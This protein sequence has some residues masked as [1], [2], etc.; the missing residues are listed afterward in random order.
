MTAGSPR[1]TSSGRVRNGKAR[2][3]AEIETD[4]DFAGVFDDT[5]RLAGVAYHE[6]APQ[7]RVGVQASHLRFI[8]LHYVY[9][10]TRGQD[11]QR[12]SDPAPV[13]VS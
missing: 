7:Q 12:F 8:A 1:L 13:A 6:P 2:R 3:R 4:H 11:G 5:S 10:R 9:Q